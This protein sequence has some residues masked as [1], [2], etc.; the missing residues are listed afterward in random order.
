MDSE[1]DSD[2]DARAGTSSTA[3][4]TKKKKVASSSDSG[5]ASSDSK[6][7]PTGKLGDVRKVSQPHAQDASADSDGDA[8]TQ[9]TSAQQGSKKLRKAAAAKT[10]LDHAVDDLRSAKAAGAL[11]ATPEANSKLPMYKKP[12]KRTM[13]TAPKN[14]FILAAARKGTAGSGLT[15]EQAGVCAFYVECIKVTVHEITPQDPP[16]PPMFYPGRGNTDAS[17][18]LTKRFPALDDATGS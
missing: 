5:D 13:R 8:R 12:S 16:V 18:C 3:R 15:P 14:H 1:T 11:H 7:Q 6:C 4:S 2:S 9:R 17:L 10:A